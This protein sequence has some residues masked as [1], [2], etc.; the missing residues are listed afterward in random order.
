MGGY[1][2]MDL[3]ESGGSMGNVDQIY[4]AHLGPCEH[5]HEHLGAIK[6]GKWVG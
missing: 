2:K 1:V 4:L 3:Q 5:S 6:L